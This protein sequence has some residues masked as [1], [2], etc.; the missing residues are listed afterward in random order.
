MGS[1]SKLYGFNLLPY[2][3]LIGPLYQEKGGP[4]VSST[5]VCSMKLGRRGK[6]ERNKE[7]ENKGAFAQAPYMASMELNSTGLDK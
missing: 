1:S 2:W 6:I 4:N 5:D 7:D 3:T